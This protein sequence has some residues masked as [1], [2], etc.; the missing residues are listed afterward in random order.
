MAGTT[1][2]TQAMIDLY[3]DYTHRTLDRRHFVAQMTKLAGGAAAAYAIIPLIEANQA[4]A[5]M[6]DEF[7]PRV[8]AE[9]RNF[10]GARG[11]MSAYF[12]RPAQQSGRLPTVVV[13][14]ENRGLNDH[15]KDVA[16]RVALEGFAALAP[17][18]LSPDGTPEDS[19]KAR[20]LIGA[21]DFPITIESAVSAV[22]FLKYN[23]RA[24]VLSNGKV[25]TIGFCWG[26]GLVNQ[27]AANTD[28]LDAGVAFY[29][30]VP[31]SADVANITAKMLLHYGS[32]DK[33]VNP[34][35]PDYKA[36]LEAAG[37][38]HTIHMYEGANHA[39]HNDTSAARYNKESAELAWSRT[40]DFLKKSLA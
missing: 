30:P 29:G 24:P 10:L 4:Q 20:D 23:R 14:H 8:N 36:S 5:A 25:G 31:D 12:A 39:F 16:R 32:L 18:F 21:L 7:D 17:D 1:K 35:I 34:G 9:M 37:I 13:I 33:F 22:S 26:G 27:V 19:D 6:V 3:D 15:I 38:D 2:I 40:I 11:A 28:L